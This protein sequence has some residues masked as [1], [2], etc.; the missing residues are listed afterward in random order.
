M[1]LVFTL[2][3]EPTAFDTERGIYGSEPPV[4]AAVDPRDLGGEDISLADGTLGVTPHGDWTSLTGVDAARQSV[5]RELPASPGSFAQRPEW[6][7]G[8]S[9]L[10]FK[11]ATSSVRDQA[12]SKARARLKANP[13]IRRV[14]EVSAT[15]PQTGVK[16]TVRADSVGGPLDLVDKVFR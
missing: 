12:V 2:S 10:L 16:M 15:L 9:G 1:P 7:G 6:G 8:L 11:G 4:T 14:L 13:R 3:P 5:V